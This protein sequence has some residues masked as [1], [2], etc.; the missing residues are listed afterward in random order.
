MVV[1]SGECDGGNKV[2]MLAKKVILMMMVV[3]V[4]VVVVEVVEEKKSGDSDGLGGGR[5]GK[6]GGE[7]D[8][9]MTLVER[10]R[11]CFK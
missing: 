6:G 10:K 2:V 11:L 4:V 1:E 8:V 7:R 3:M 9:A 5:L